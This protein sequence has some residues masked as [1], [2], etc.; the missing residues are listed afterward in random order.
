MDHFQGP[1]PAGGISF[2]IPRRVKRTWMNRE[3][4][5]CWK[6]TYEMRYTKIVGGALHK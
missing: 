5:V 4:L 3:H 6:S 1:D 2:G